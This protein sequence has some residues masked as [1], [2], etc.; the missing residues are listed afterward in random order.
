MINNNQ[1]RM[2]RYNRIKKEENKKEVKESVIAYNI[3]WTLDKIVFGLL[4]AFGIVVMAGFVF[5]IMMKL[6]G[7]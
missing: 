1:T 2:E 6:A 4:I 3:L 7:L 5:Q